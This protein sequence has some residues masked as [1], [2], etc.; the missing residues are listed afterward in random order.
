MKMLPAFALTTG[1]LLSLPAAETSIRMNIDGIKRQNEISPDMNAKNIN[2]ARF[3]WLK[4]A[5]DH[6]FT[7][8]ETT[9][10]KVSADWQVH[11]FIFIPA[12]TGNI[13]ISIEGTWAAK[14]EDRAW[15][16][17]NKIEKTGSPVKNGDFRKSFTDKN[18]KIHPMDFR[19]NNKAVYLVNGGKDG[20]PAIA[21]SYNNPVS[22]LVNV[23]GGKPCT[24]KI[25]AKT[26]EAPK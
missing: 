14:S 5:E 15:L 13:S 7:L 4:N 25:E 2:I 8:I 17:I 3:S 21:V 20:A 12:K 6:K 23:E 9:R 10:N 26:V 19:L 11:E 24:V 16:A 22:F 18:G 1:I